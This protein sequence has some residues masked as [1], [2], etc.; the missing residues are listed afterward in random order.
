MVKEIKRQIRQLGLA[1][2]EDIPSV[3]KFINTETYKRG[4]KVLTKQESMKNLNSM[5]IKLGEISRAALVAGDRTKSSLAISL[6]GAI[7]KDFKSWKGTTGNRKVAADRIQAARDFS[8]S[9]NKYFRKGTVGKLLGYVKGADARVTDAAT[10]PAILTGRGDARLDKALDISNAEKFALSVTGN[11]TDEL[12]TLNG[13]SQ[14][15]SAQFLIDAFD[16]RVLNPTK[17][18]NFLKPMKVYFN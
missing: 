5:Y 10:A 2:L 11:S 7:L 14:N 9:K 17:A 12:V 13:L 1:Q 3:A 4:G 15:L 16:D 18:R 8:L 6:Q